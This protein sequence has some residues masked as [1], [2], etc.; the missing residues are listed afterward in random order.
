M[1]EALYCIVGASG[2]RANTGSLASWYVVPHRRIGRY[3][4]ACNTSVVDDGTC[5]L[6]VT[7]TTSSASISVEQR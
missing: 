7:S 3:S 1:N 4:S 6:I 5:G 2:P